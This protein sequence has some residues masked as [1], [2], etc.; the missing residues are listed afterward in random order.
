MKN[1]IYLFLLLSTS[2]F[3]YV[4]ATPLCSDSYYFG[5]D[6][7]YNSATHFPIKYDAACFDDGLDQ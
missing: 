7:S 5:I 1:I 4:A 3:A 2:A 6:S